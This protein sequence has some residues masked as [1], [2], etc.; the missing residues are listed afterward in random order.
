MANY[1]HNV[2]RVTLSGTMFTGTEQWSTGFFLGA[3]SDDAPDPTQQSADDIR[4]AWTTFFTHADSKVSA[5]YR[6]TQ[7]K[8]AKLDDNGQTIDGTVYYSSPATTVA[9]TVN[10]IVFPPQCSLVVT[11]LSDRPRGKASKGRMYLPG[12]TPNMDINTGKVQASHV[13]GIADRMKAFFDALAGDADTPG[14]LI[15]A[16]K[17]SGVMNVNPAQNDWV[18]TI[19]VGDVMDTQRRRRNQLVETYTSRVL[20]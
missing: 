9:G 14:Q 19:R 5:S 4:D 12:I 11:L 7:A 17:S 15:L 6:F 2:V 8:V 16:A 13:T 10:G 1:A 3:E 20:A 18:E